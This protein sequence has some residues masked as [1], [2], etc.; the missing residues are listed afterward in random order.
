MDNHSTAC[1]FK[2]ALLFGALACSNGVQASPGS[3]AVTM[4]TYWYN[5]TARDCGSGRLASDCSGI[6]LR[7]I[8]SRQPWLPWDPSPYSHSIEGAG[9]EYPSVSRGGV[10][11][12]YLRVDAEFDGFGLLKQ[13][14]FALTPNDFINQDKQFS[15]TVLCAFPLDAWSNHRV[16][17]G[18]GDYQER[19][20]T[21]G[22]V[23]DYCQKISV[24]NAKTWMEHY[25]RQSNGTTYKAHKFSCAFDT[26][27]RYFDT[28][29]KADAFNTFIEARKL[30][31]VTPDTL[32]DT[33]FTQTELRLETWPDNQYWSRD[34]KLKT[35]Y[36]DAPPAVNTPAADKTYKEL[37]I[38]AFL[39]VGGIDYVDKDA[40]AFVAR[41]LAR[42]DQRR[43]V[44]QGNS[45]KPVIKMQF[46]KT[47]AHDAKFAFTA[48][49][50]YPDTKE[51]VDP[52]SCAKYIEKAQWDD[53]YRDPVLGTISS[54]KV[55]PTECARK[56]GVGKTSVVFAELA[57]MAANDRNREWSFD[58]IGS[59]MRRQVACILDTPDIAESKPTWNL[60]PRRPYV[61]HDVIM[62]LE[63]DNR[64][65]PH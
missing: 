21:L 19:G 48:D 55:T 6:M 26:T 31:A 30:L 8:E 29:N 51:P 50:Q 59:S 63:G 53:S 64:C 22:V 42:D 60:E 10:S 39:Y 25:K 34:W 4:M 52:R 58:N 44:Q 56:A 23:E 54:L 9:K 28:Y 33:H 35:P 14:G 61:A 17:M 36:F 24:S 46:P 37:P 62:K 43:W 15:T 65:N 49:D 40:R 41:D 1:G 38:H 20:D 16:D 11:V 2:S 18:C 57:N 13:N 32:Q 3:D 7:G 45:W 47:T 12:S 5:L 27:A